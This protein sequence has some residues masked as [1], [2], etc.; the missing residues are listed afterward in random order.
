MFGI[1]NFVHNMSGEFIRSYEIYVMCI[2]QHLCFAHLNMIGNGLTNG[3]YDISSYIW[4]R[5]TLHYEAINL[6]S[7]SRWGS[8]VTTTI[9]WKWKMLCLKML[10]LHFHFTIY[11]AHFATLE[12]S[13]AK[14]PCEN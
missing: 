6:F 4:R 11:Y 3:L 5:M 13:R 9:E 8:T 14:K 12:S 2:T 10:M 1:Q 7:T